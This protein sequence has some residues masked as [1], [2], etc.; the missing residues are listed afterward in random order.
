M[1]FFTP[2]QHR[3]RRDAKI[4]PQQQKRCWWSG[5]ISS[6]KTAD[7]TTIMQ[8]ATL[9][10]PLRTQKVSEGRPQVDI[11]AG[12]DA[13]AHRRLLETRRYLTVNMDRFQ[14]E[15]QKAEARCC[16]ILPTRYL[17]PDKSC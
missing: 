9:T 2:C 1:I 6:T 15:D 13:D 14:A 7:E 8:V 10:L 16:D 5:W 3:S 12:R 17:E 11:P 4:I